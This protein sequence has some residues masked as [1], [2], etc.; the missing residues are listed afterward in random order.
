MRPKYVWMVLLLLFVAIR[1]QAEESITPDNRQLAEKYLHVVRIFADKVLEHGR[2]VYG[3]IKTPLFVDGINVD[4]LEPAIWIRDGKKRILSNQASQQNLFRTLVGLSAATGDPKYR[5]AVVEAI[6]YAFEHLRDSSGLL[7]W[8]GHAYYDALADKPTGGLPESIMVH[9]LKHHNP[10]YELMWLIDPEATR[11]YIE[12][13]WDAHVLNWENLDVNRHG[14]YGRTPDNVWQHD[15]KGGP[16]PFE[17]TGLSFM[18]S[19]SDFFYAA[20][21]LSYLSGDDQPLVWAKRLASRYVEARHP[22]TQL[23]ASNFTVHTTHRMEKQFPQFN[24]RF[25]E[26]TVTDIYGS[27]YSDCA[28][29]QL[30][31][32]EILGPKGQDFLRWG[33]EDLTARATYGYDEKTNSFSA[34]LIDGTVLSPADRINEGYV[35]A[36]WL[37]PRVADM[38]YFYAYAK[39]YK[40]SKKQLMWKMVRSI[41]RGLGLGDL[42]ETPDKSEKINYRTPNYDPII[43]FGLLELHEAIHS[44]AYLK[45]AMRVADNALHIRFN[46]GF[47]VESRECLFSKFDE[48]M[49]LALLHLRAA[50]LN[51]SEYPPAYTG[52]RGFYHG[53]YDG[54]D[55]TYDT[56]VIYRRFREKKENSQSP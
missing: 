38:C 27:R 50:L 12:A 26:A 4:T 24:G 42:G 3:P 5:D 30:H 48:C 45:L 52:S 51:L 43:I 55:R 41:G 7:Y 36:S 32:A 49:P 34:M 39:A 28:I 46:N 18:H 6:R 54:K 16:V 10:F 11:R 29:C 1:A 23:G 15:Y 35:K 47:F 2:D 44:D 31:L 19:G 14:K 53:Y 13:V 56:Y 40:L 33:I 20:A 17:S 9:E 22:E 25:T 21:L 37:S 8:G